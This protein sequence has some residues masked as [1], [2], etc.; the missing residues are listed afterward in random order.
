MGDAHQAMSRF[1]LGRLR[2]I[3]FRVKIKNI[4]AYCYQGPLAFT[5][6]SNYAKV[7]KIV[8]QLSLITR[9]MNVDLNTRPIQHIIMVNHIY[10]VPETPVQLNM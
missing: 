9:K 4:M 7:F 10:T 2:I 8:D 6:V 3:L 1:H 5:S